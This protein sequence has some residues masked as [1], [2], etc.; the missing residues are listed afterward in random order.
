M[1][2]EREVARLEAEEAEWI[3]KLQN[4]NQIQATAFGE[5][6][7]AL[8]GDPNEIQIT[9][10]KFWAASH[11][12]ATVFPSVTEEKLWLPLDRTEARETKHK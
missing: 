12:R 10:S 8:N 1:Q 2:I 5:L 7:S 9:P 6:E 3:K 11:K 4:T